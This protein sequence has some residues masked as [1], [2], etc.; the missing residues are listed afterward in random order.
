[1]PPFATLLSNDDVA[2]LLTHVRASWGNQGAPVSA[3]DVAKF[4]SVK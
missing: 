4:R 3:L 2:Q 1:M